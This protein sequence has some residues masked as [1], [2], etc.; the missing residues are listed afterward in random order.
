[1]AAED[2]VY[3]SISER[4]VRDLENAH[5]AASVQNRAVS[6]VHALM[7]VAAATASNGDCFVADPPKIASAVNLDMFLAAKSQVHMPL[8]VDSEHNAYTNTIAAISAANERNIEML[9]RLRAMEAALLD[10]IHDV[11]LSHQR[12]GQ[13]LTDITRRPAGGH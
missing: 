8:V 6:S 7:T 11:E 13:T 2:C 4:F 12:L 10:A 3:I 9:S 5:I 1:M